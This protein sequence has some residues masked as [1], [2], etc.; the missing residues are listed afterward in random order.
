MGGKQGSL[1]PE[2][3]LTAGPA[4]LGG[5]GPCVQASLHPLTQGRPRPHPHPVPACPRPP[6]QAHATRDRQA[7][8]AANQSISA[9]DFPAGA[10]AACKSFRGSQLCQD[11][12]PFFIKKNGGCCWLW[13]WRY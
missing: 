5:T 9:A 12:E 11:A 4:E 10:S 7:G 1:L 2:E 6:A 13:K 8:P 3:G